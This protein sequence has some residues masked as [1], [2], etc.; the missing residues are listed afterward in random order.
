M[1]V[2]SARPDVQARTATDAAFRH[3]LER[4]AVWSRMISPGAQVPDLP[5]VEADLG[6]IFLRRLLHTGPLVLIFFAHAGAAGCE[7]ALTAYEKSL[8][9]I[10]AHIVAVSPQRPER[11]AE[12]KH[13]AGLSMLVAS[14]PRH[15][16]IDAFNIGFS[17]PATTAA[18]GTGRSTLPYPAV[19][20]AG[21]T[22][23]VR[24][25][26]VHSDRSTRTGAPAIAEALRNG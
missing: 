5:L 15:A 10:D 3:Q 24:L 17:S 7:Q 8:S 21:R 20:V 18:L 6:P 1:T 12:H 26:D 23:V 9:G 14:D 19:V 25:V 16:L 22:G 4:D 11:L 13:R 2:T